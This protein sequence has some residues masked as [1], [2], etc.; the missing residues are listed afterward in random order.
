MITILKI[1]LS[2]NIY[3]SDNLVMIKEEALY[4]ND[5]TSIEKYNPFDE[6][7]YF[8]DGTNEIVA[9]TSLAWY[10]IK[11]ENRKS[12]IQDYIEYEKLVYSYCLGLTTQTIVPDDNFYNCA[13][14]TNIAFNYLKTYCHNNSRCGELLT[15]A[16]N[17][18]IFAKEEA[19]QR[20]WKLHN[21]KYN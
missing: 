4:H 10:T 2:M 7:R 3:A 6:S 18:D 5:S 16:F 1:L 11:I 17:H 20:A 13:Y 14:K 19:R 9:L 21:S 12:L 8:I 15:Q